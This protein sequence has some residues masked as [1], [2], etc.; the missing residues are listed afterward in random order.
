MISVDVMLSTTDSDVSFQRFLMFTFQS[1]LGRCS[2]LT[3]V[4]ISPGITTGSRRGS[5][6][7]HVEVDSIVKPFSNPTAPA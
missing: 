2:Q 1:Y 5:L 3:I 6:S 4:V 7:P